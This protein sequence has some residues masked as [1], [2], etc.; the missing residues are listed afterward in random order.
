MS[1]G[2]AIASAFAFAI[3]VGGCLGSAPDPG[4]AG[5]QL[6][7]DLPAAFPSQIVG[8]EFENNPPLDPPTLFID[9]SGAMSP[10]EQ[11]RFLCEEIVPAIDRTGAS[12][13][14]TV[15]YGWSTEDCL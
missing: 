14:A 10:D 4:A 3:V 6:A 12:I 9:V 15:S 1:K 5:E 2:A 13:P 7:K 8:T 11:L